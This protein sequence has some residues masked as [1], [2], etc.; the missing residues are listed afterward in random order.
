MDIP[1]PKLQSIK[2]ET[3]R[4]NFFKKHSPEDFISLY[5]QMREEGI[6]Y[7]E[8]IDPYGNI[9][10][11]EHRL[12]TREEASKRYAKEINIYN[13]NNKELYN[14]KKYLIYQCEQL[15][16]TVLEKDEII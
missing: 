13:N 8:I 1:D 12:E 5:A 11:Y 2:V 9:V 14:R 10:V 4:F 16:L 15:G 6:D 3:N 7:L